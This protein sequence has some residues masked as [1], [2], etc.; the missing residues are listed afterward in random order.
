MANP[1]VECRTCHIQRHR[2]L[3]AQS[4]ICKMCEPI[5]WCCYICD[6]II[7]RP[8]NF[9]EKC[10]KEPYWKC[11]KCQEILPTSLPSC[12]F[13][14]PKWKCY[15]CQRWE[16]FDSKECTFC[17]LHATWTC[18]SCRREFT[19][20]TKQC[21]YCCNTHRGSPYLKLCLV[22]IFVLITRIT[23]YR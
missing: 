20:V 12:I 17:K 7:A 15:S 6:T 21:P 2:T 14:A 19:A 22:F 11:N 18:Y 23:K 1:L 16:S 4:G 8:T 5:V 10:E 9:C 13:C 3:V